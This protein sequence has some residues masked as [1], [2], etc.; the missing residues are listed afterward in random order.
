MTFD[1]YPEESSW[2]VLDAS[3]SIIFSSGSYEDQP[4]GGVIEESFQLADGEYRFVM[5]DSYGDGIC[6]GYGSG[7]F[8]LS[9]GNTIVRKGS[10]FG[11]SDT[12]LLCFGLDNPSPVTDAIAPSTPQL[13]SIYNITHNTAKVSWS[14]SSDNTG[15][16]GYYIFLNNVLQGFVQDTIFALNGLQ[17]LTSYTVGIQASDANNNLSQIARSDFQT[18]EYIDIQPPSDPSGLFFTHITY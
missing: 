1:N 3:N 8:I 15:V 7:A 6:C 9:I 12:T 17:E 10:Y 13:L 16:T 2:E 5:N 14:P 18:S 11:V 4:D